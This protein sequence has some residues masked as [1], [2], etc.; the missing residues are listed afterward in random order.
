MLFGA[1][2][3]NFVTKAI[4]IFDFFPRINNSVNTGSRFLLLSI[5]VNHQIEPI[6][7]PVLGLYSSIFL[8]T[9]VVLLEYWIQAFGSQSSVKPTLV[10]LFMSCLYFASNWL[11]ILL[12]SKFYQYLVDILFH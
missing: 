5:S 4:K 11:E 12:G 6:Y 3:Y 2:K 7:L 10:R 1:L 8:L 9:F